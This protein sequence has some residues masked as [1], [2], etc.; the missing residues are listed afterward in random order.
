MTI[1]G[2]KTHHPK[3]QVYFRVGFG[4]LYANFPYGWNVKH[5]YT[6]MFFAE[7]EDAIKYIEKYL[8]QLCKHFTD[9]PPKWSGQAKLEFDYIQW[10]K[11]EELTYE[12]TW[13][14]TEEIAR[15]KTQVINGEAWV[16]REATLARE[17]RSIVRKIEIVPMFIHCDEKMIIL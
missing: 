16:S 6:L 5:D 10:N 11:I 1:W 8:K 4:G 15:Y 7:R 2:E 13:A 9:F 3:E 14:Y 17:N 12:L